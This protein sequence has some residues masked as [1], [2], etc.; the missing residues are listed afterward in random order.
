MS[1]DITDQM[2]C[3]LWDYQFDSER[4][5]AA[6]KLSMLR[7]ERLAEAIEQSLQRLEELS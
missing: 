7:A 1:E 3:L 5:I 6:V 4:L 2:W